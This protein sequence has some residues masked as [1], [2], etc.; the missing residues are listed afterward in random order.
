VGLHA[1]RALPLG[2]VATALLLCVLG[3]R[4]DWGVSDEVAR[5]LGDGSSA[6]AAAH[7]G[8]WMLALFCVAPALVARAAAT[9]PRWRAGESAWLGTRAVAPL[10]CVAAGLAGPVL[11]ALALLA[12]FA[13]STEIAAGPRPDGDGPQ[14]AAELEHAP[15]ALLSGDAEATRELRGDT[16]AG[17][18]LRIALIEVPGHSSG[19]DVEVKVARGAA[20]LGEARARVV[21]RALVDVALREGDNG[22]GPL[23]LRL[24]RAGEATPSGGGVV[25][26]A[27][28][29]R[30]LALDAGARRGSLVLFARAALALV[31]MCAVA[32][33]LGAWMRASLAALVTLAAWLAAWV[34]GVGAERL[35]GADL[36][37]A[38]ALL[39]EGIAPPAPSAAM[40]LATAVI[41][42]LS[43]ALGR[44]GLWDGRG[45]A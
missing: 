36:P 30:L 23:A 18:V 4:R 38:L 2:L 17:G 14:L 11:G 10:A 29:A 33:A 8:M 40:L 42:G 32:L 25:V 16:R 13:V 6:R 5:A 15:L 28:S 35:P 34:L 9:L 39:G 19:V 43:L 24:R 3:A 21:G 7:Q 44:L 1:R 37:A 22:E 27:D 20:V 41:V 31:A 45:A 26:R 12:A